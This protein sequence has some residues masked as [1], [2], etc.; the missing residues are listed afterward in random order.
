MFD[1]SIEFKRFIENKIEEIIDD[2]ERK[3][4]KYAK[5]KRYSIENSKKYRE[6]INKLPEEEREFI[7]EYNNN[8]YD[9][10][11]IEREEFYYRGCRDCLKFL[12]LLGVI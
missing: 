11:T 4:L 9:I 12:K 5:Y 10:R 8:S 3:N 6:V 2:I 7:N 1:F